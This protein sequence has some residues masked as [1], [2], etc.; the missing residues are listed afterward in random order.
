MIG[1]KGIDSGP[2]GGSS[3]VSR[4]RL[5]IFLG[6]APGVGKTCALLA[7]GR[8]LRDSGVDVVAGFVDTRGR[9]GTAELLEGLEVLSGAS[10]A[11]ASPSLAG[12]DLD[13]ALARRPGALLLDD[14]E[15]PNAPGSRH[16]RR[17]QDLGELLDEGIPVLAT[18]D[19]YRLESLNDVVLQITGVRVGDTVPDSILERA[20]EIV[21]V[22]VPPGEIVARVG[23]V[24]AAGAA[25]DPFGDP[26]ILLALRELALRQAAEKVDADIRAWRHDHAIGTMWPAS[27]RILA[28]VGPSPSSGGVV[29]AAVRIAAGLHSP[30]TAAYVESPGARPMSADDRDRLQAHLQL[31]ES[32]GGEVIRLSGR[33]VG[34]ALLRHAQERNVTRIVVGRPTHSR[35][36]ELWKGSI[37]SA[38]VRGSGGIEVHFIAGSGEADAPARTSRVR[39]TFEWPGFLVAF[40]LVA[41][42][43]A[44]ASL[45]RT[46]LPDSEIVMVFL[47]AIMI[48]AYFFGRGPSLA[49]AGLSVAA[50]D[51]FFIPPLFRL[52]VA[53]IRHVLT[54]AMMFVVGLAISSLTGRLRRQGSEARLRERRTADLYALVREL[55]GA[56]EAEPAAGIA[57]RHTATAFG[58][59]AVVLLRDPAMELRVAGASN[60]AVRLDAEETAT[61]RWV[62]E[63][64][65][66]AGRG[67]ETYADAPV[68]C[69]PI[70]TG[71]SVLGVLA[72]RSADRVP[73]DAE[74]RGFLEA[75]VRQIALTME[76]VRLGGE[77]RAAALRARTEEIRTSLLSAV[78]HDLRTPLAAITGA[79]SALRM[80]PGQLGAERHAELVDTI[81]DEAGRMDRLIGNILDMVRLEAGGAAAKR[82][83]V[84]L[85]EIIG[86]ALARLEDRLA[87]R[88][89]RLDLPADLPLIPVDPVLFEHLLF[90]LIENAVKHAPGA[91]PID[92]SARAGE[93]WVQVEVADRGPGLPPGD[94]RRVFD[95]FYRGPTAQ[96]TGMGL[97]LAICRSIALVHEGSLTAENRPGGGTIFRLRLPFLDRP[98]ESDLLG[99]PP[100]GGE[101]TT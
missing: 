84:P 80:D 63:H 83:W 99:D 20:D 24:A 90:N 33:R 21:L 73:S 40:L 34:D 93:G 6:Y 98:P 39:R 36:R 27:E 95:K 74:Q 16:A 79:G 59:D 66:P 5:K 18:L 25:A 2:A 88:E 26:G 76:R 86:P 82:E 92:L 57:A 56:T 85:E 52:T 100:S 96:G 9:P 70:A 64:G 41:G 32:L 54:F 12:F 8:R 13:A 31:V 15:R 3:R 45:V 53:D 10:I 62:G 29:R 75:F 38:L 17:W 48:V 22:D 60:P 61:A 44:G 4:A 69:V 67:T 46:F 91:G 68:V 7:D 50:Y 43:T 78:S 89:V 37:V 35:L 51:V 28:C 58:G 94:E 101:R 87:D 14:I 19:A 42:V 30:W 81:C 1:I 47:L 55:A 77:A 11:H 49:A 72:L 23:T 71:E 97:G 65:R